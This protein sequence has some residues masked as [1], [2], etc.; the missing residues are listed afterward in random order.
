MKIELDSFSSFFYIALTFLISRRNE[1]LQPEIMYIMDPEEILQFCD[2]FGGSKMYVPTRK[3]LATD[4]KAAMVMYYKYCQDMTEFAI[5]EKLNISNKEMY[6][7][8]S[9]IGHYLEYIK[10]EGLIPPKI[11]K[12]LTDAGKPRT[13]SSK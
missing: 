11:M 12:G 7:I 10:S 6:T 4:L 13:R 8:N 5:K 3:E 1:G 2:L 9:K